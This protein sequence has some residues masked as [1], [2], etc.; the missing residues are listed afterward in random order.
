MKLKTLATILALMA[1]ISLTFIWCGGDDDDVVV[2]TPPTPATPTPP[3]VVCVVGDTS[4]GIGA[5]TKLAKS[6][7]DD[8][9]L[10]K[11]YTTYEGVTRDNVLALGG[12]IDK[13]WCELNTQVC[14][15]TFDAAAI[16]TAFNNVITDARVNIVAPIAADAI[17]SVDI[18]SELPTCGEVYKIEKFVLDLQDINNSIY[19][20]IAG[21]VESF[22]IT[23]E[24]VHEVL[25]KNLVKLDTD[26]KLVSTLTAAGVTSETC[27]YITWTAAA[28][29]GKSLESVWNLIGLILT[30]ET[31]KTKW[32]DAM[33]AVVKEIKSP[34]VKDIASLLK[35]VHDII[36]AEKLSEVCGLL[37][38][39]PDLLQGFISDNLT[40]KC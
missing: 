40:S 17:L 5:G 6:L 33:V 7:W 25:V 16:E 2:T 39:L 15:T 21:V 14:A 26:F 13:L 24:K 11:N 32:I 31:D 18:D 8:Y 22:G 29:E 12:D 19:D 9:C 1:A 35:D 34:L 23:K 37:G 3:T 30:K 27:T 10:F 4:E 28:G 20:T 36:P 38:L